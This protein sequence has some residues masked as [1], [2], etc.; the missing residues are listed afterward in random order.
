MRVG[1]DSRLLRFAYQLHRHEVS[2]RALDR[3]LGICLFLVGLLW[4]WG[5]LPGGRWVAVVAALLLV[6]LIAFQVWARRAA[7]VRFTPSD[8]QT[9]PQRGEKLSPEDKIAIRAT[10][11][12]EVE[13]RRQFFADLQAFFRTFAT[14][15]HAVIAYVPK[16]RFLG[17]GRWPGHEVGMWYIFFLPRQ[18]I[19]LEWGDLIFGTRR[20]PASRITYRGEKR[21]ETIYLSFDGEEERRRVWEDILC[22]AD[23]LGDE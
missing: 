19:S 10:G 5:W 3:W 6:G 1:L 14:R 7:Y 20:R 22:D 8:A 15:E 17:I 11:H 23:S 2:G 16:S 21:P 18:V 13:G 4:A 9:P 12:F